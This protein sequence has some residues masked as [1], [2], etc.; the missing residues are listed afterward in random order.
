MRFALFRQVPKRQRRK[1]RK[2]NHGGIRKKVDDAEGSEDEDETDTEDEQGQAEATASYHDLVHRSGLE[3]AAAIKSSVAEL[4]DG[5]A[6]IRGAHSSF[7][8]MCVLV[9]KA[10]TPGGLTHL[11][12]LAS[13]KVWY[14]RTMDDLRIQSVHGP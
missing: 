3:T 1:K 2:L 14:R 5:L 7:S 13:D 8:H 10:Y 4:S 6:H 12:C 9:E 11:S